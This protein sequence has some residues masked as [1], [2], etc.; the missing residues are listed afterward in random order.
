S[1][2]TSSCGASRIACRNATSCVIVL[3]RASEPGG[4]ERSAAAGKGEF[5]GAT[6]RAL[7]SRPSPGSLVARRLKALEQRLQRPQ[8]LV[9]HLRR[10]DRQADVLLARLLVAVAHRPPRLAV[11]ALRRRRELL[12]QGGPHL[13]Q[14][15][16][17]ARRR[18]R[19][20]P[21][22][23]LLLPRLAALLLWL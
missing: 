22:P 18:R 12:E 4:G 13:Q 16:P 8:R 1:R 15:R 9:D 2:G 11:G 20:R 23:L 10:R 3:P 6:A 19:S 21:A 14:P 7:R 17:R 5:A